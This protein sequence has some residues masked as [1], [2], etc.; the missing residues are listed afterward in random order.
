MFLK[1][2]AVHNKETSV[3]LCQVFDK[4]DQHY[5]VLLEAMNASKKFETAQQAFSKV[6]C[7]S[8]SYILRS[9]ERVGRPCFTTSIPVTAK[10]S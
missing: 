4:T 9:D 8:M 6:C 10:V 7:D 1:G 3:E 2:I 5:E